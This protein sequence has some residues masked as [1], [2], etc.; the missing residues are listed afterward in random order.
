M[1]KALPICLFLLFN[2]S[3]VFAEESM[4]SLKIQELENGIY[5]H[6]S[7]E[8]YDGFGIVASNG[9][10]AIDNGRAYI[11]DTPTSAEDT[12]RLVE[13]AIE[14][15]FIVEASIST[16]FHDDST[17]GIEWLNSQSIPT[18]ASR[19]TNRLLGE[20]D[21][22]QAINSFDK[23]L[24]WLIE[25]LIEVFYPGAGHTK[26]N[27]VVWLPKQGVLY[28]GCFVKT[29][30]LGNL[31]DAVIEAWPESA[32]NLISRYG[33]AELVVPGHGKVGDASLLVRTRALALEAVSSSNSIQPDAKT[34]D[35]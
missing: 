26:D 15:E 7:F 32:Q 13:W 18:Y 28:G 1:K 8:R 22:T 33:N 24:F 11:I 35:D 20:S 23:T 29:Q 16:H 21:Q 14:R 27:V 12:R 17:A 4:P 31:S 5:L 2:A 3:F 34:S 25:D 9:L 10:I 6:T 19:L 30:S